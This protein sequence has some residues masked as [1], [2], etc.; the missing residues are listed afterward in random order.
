MMTGA[1]T[2][3]FFII[4]IKLGDLSDVTFLQFLQILKLNFF[5]SQF[6]TPGSSGVD[7]FA[8]DWA[9]D[10]NWLVPPINLISKAIKHIIHCQAKGV[11]VVP[12]W[13]SS[14]FWPAIVDI[15]GNFRW[16]IKQHVKY[17]KP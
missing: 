12:K 4:L 15:T 7:A 2:K 5:S 10:M 9:Q 17:E 16:F 1:Y 3:I 6:W 8:F 11:L 13:K 14:V